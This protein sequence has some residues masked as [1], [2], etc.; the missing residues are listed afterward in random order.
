M[1]DF[2]FR[3]TIFDIVIQL[4]F[5]FSR[6]IV[7]IYIKK[8]NLRFSSEIIKFCY[9]LMYVF[10]KLLGALSSTVFLSIKSLKILSTR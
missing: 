3:I 6:E 4:F 9:C 10:V 8:G 1:I 7:F 5:S 2:I